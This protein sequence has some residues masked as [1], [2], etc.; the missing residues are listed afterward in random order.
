MKQMAWFSHPVLFDPCP[1]DELS[2]AMRRSASDDGNENHQP[3]NLEIE[4]RELIQTRNDLV[5]KN[6][7]RCG[8]DVQ[9]LVDDERVPS[10]YLERPVV[11][12]NE[13]HDNL[14]K[15]EI[16]GSSGE[17]PFE[18]STTTRLHSV[19]IIDLTYIPAH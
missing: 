8:D 14:S 10:L 2:A 4:K 12:S 9:T 13:G 7:N 16:G 3:T 1:E 18:P 6:D 15:D 19:V 11:Q 5:T 17:N